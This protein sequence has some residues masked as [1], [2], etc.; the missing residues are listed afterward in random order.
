M[1]QR[2][3]E[4]RFYDCYAS[5]FHSRPDHDSGSGSYG[6]NLPMEDMR[7]P[8][9]PKFTLPVFEDLKK[10]FKMKDGRVF[11][12]PL[13]RH[14]R[15]GIGD[16]KHPR[17]RRQGSDEPLRTVLAALGRYG[18]AHGLKV[19]LC[20]EDGAPAFRSRNTPIS[21]Q[22]QEPRDQSRPSPR[23]TKPRPASLPISPACARRSMPPSTPR[24][25]SS[26]ASRPSLA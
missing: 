16:R 6:M 15:L 9:F 13:V 18:R 8:E 25:S 10:V 23:T 17:R 24:Y 1:A 11:I 14:W 19:E 4:E 5:S 22:G 2:S 3:A 21:R 7:S 26:T 20:D 12:F